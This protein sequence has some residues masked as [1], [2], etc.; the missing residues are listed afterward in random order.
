MKTSK[1]KWNMEPLMS[2][3]PQDKRYKHTGNVFVKCVIHHLLQACRKFNNSGSCVPL[4]PQTLIYNK[5][6]FKLEPNPNAKYQYGS[7]CVAQCPSESPHVAL[8]FINLLV[9]WRPTESSFKYAI[10]LVVWH[11]FVLFFVCFISS[12]NYLT[13]CPFVFFSKLSGGWHL[14]CQQLSIL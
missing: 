8:F 5:H 1:N 11:L 9:L 3:K 13:K 7:I 12:G 6:T 14:L 4:C 10:F 2:W